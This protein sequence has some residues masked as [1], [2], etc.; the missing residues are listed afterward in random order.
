MTAEEVG[1]RL[2]RLRAERGLTQRALAEPHYTAAYVSSVETGARTPSGDALRH[3]AE[4]LG[5]EADELLGGTSPRDVVRLDL[6]LALAAGDFLD[7]VDASVRLR[8]IARR[9]ER[10]GRR[11][12]AGLA[13]LWLARFS[14]G[15]ARAKL[16]TAAESAFTSDVA[17]YRGLVVPLRATVLDEWGEPHYAMHLLQTCHD[18]L[19]RDGYPHPLL[20]LTLRAHLA[21][22]HLRLG[23]L[24]QAA[25]FADD[26]LRLARGRDDVL[27]EL[28]AYQLD[29]CRTFL[30]DEHFTDA[31]TAVAVAH[32]LLHERALRPAIAR[33]LLVRARVRPAGALADLL[34]AREATVPG[35]TRAI[36]LELA[37]VSRREGR[38]DEALAFLSEITVGDDD[39]LAAAVRYQL[40]ALAVSRGD[41]SSAETEL[42]QAIDLATRLDARDVLVR[43]LDHAGTLLASQGRLDEA[44]DLL[45]EGLLKLGAEKDS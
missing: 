28:I 9:A 39:P 32:D 23:N 41:A 13:W 34:A 7:G 33:C 44:A 21:E 35:D 26:A 38:L 4:Q 27:S 19:M 36:T 24:A 45:R 3:F 31:A 12:Q 16:V 30:A 2:R 42:S 15:D 14:S 29:L 40:G 1:A 43:S 37:E 11:R 10:M 22:G 20:L 18:E 5:I 6:D 17:P 8:R 25:P